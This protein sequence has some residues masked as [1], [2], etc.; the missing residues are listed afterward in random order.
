M[1][2]GAGQANHQLAERRPLVARA[3]SVYRRADVEWISPDSW[4]VRDGAEPLYEQPLGSE[5]AVRELWSSPAAELGL[6]LLASLYDEGFYRIIL[7]EG[8]KIGQ[9]MNELATLEGYWVRAVFDAAVRADLLE[10]V[11]WLRVALNMAASCGG[12]VSIG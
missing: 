9:V 4:R 8:R 6:P 2:T 11:N 12:W 7:W 5:S 3:L 10:R 1:L